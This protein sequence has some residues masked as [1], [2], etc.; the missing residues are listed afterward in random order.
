[1]VGCWVYHSR[2]WKGEAGAGPDGP[3]AG[4]AVDIAIGVQPPG[5][6]GVDHARGAGPL[7]GGFPV[8]IGN[9]ERTG[10]RQGGALRVGIGVAFTQ[11]REGQGKDGPLQGAHLPVAVAGSVADFGGADEGADVSVQ[12]VFVGAVKPAIQ[13]AAGVGVH[14]AVV[15]RPVVIAVLSHH[16]LAARPIQIAFIIAL[17]FIK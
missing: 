1:M 4:A 16:Q 3:G 15:P 5:V 9:L 7:S 14:I 12:H 13:V 17:G 2:G 6:E 11:L 10:N 8:Q